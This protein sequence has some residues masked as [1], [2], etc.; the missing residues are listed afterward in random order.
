MGIFAVH[1]MLSLTTCAIGF[2]LNH[3]NCSGFVVQMLEIE[4]AI[5]DDEH[6]GAHDS[7]IQAFSEML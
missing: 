1:Q 7:R 4:I 6:T 2:T 5:E 3:H